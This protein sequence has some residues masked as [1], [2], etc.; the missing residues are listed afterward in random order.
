M[1]VPKILHFIA[2][3]LGF[4]ASA[5]FVFFLISKGGSELIDGKWSVIPILLMMIVTVGGY[6]WAIL[7]SKPGGIIMILGGL[8]MAVYLLAMGGTSEIKM[9]FIYGLPFIIPG[10]I[11]YFSPIKTSASEKNVNK[12]EAI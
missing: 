11:F 1:N 7:R 10:I 8:L 2:L 6:I 5:F 3:I 12:P 9:A 4:Q